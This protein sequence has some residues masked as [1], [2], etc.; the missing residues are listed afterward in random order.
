[1]PRP[2]RR[3]R[4]A[5]GRAAAPPVWGPGCAPRTAGTPRDFWADRKGRRRVACR[6]RRS[7]RN[8]PRQRRRWA[9]RVEI[10]SPG[11]TAAA[12]IQA[13]PTITHGAEWSPSCARIDRLK[14]APPLC[15]DAEAVVGVAEFGG[16]AAAGGTPG[17]LDVV[18]RKS[19]V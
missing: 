11:A 17:E 15:H 18:D 1:M 12:Q 9:R 7:A 6:P 16:D 2:R 5:S 19:V 10:V 3:G 8:P 4:R 13:F 14:P